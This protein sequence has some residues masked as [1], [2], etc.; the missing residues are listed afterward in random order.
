M[1][2]ES[3][4]GRCARTDD[5]KPGRGSASRSREH[6]LVSSATATL[7][8]R[9]GRSSPRNS[10]PAIS[11]E[12]GDAAGPGGSEHVNSLVAG[13]IPPELIS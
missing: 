6:S 8:Q 10:V 5:P 11:G 9:H 1:P 7:A 2:S 4:W 3:G 12:N 13:T